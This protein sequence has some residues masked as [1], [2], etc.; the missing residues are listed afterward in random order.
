MI[1]RRLG[2]LV[3]SRAARTRRR[4]APRP[5][6]PDGRRGSAAI[7]RSG[8]SIRGSFRRR[9][10]RP[11]LGSVRCGAVGAADRR[12]PGCE[13]L[14]LAERDLAGLAQ[15]E[16][17][18][19]APR[20]ARRARAPRPR[21]RS[22][23]RAGARAARGSARGTARRAG[24]AAPCGR[25]RRSAAEPRAHEARRRAL[26]DPAARAGARLAAR[27]APARAGTSGPAPS[28]S[29][30]SEP[31]GCLLHPPVLGEPSRELLGGLLRLELAE[32]GGLVRE[33][34]ARLQL[35]QR[36]DEDEELAAGLE[37][38]LVTLGHALDEREDDRRDV[39]LARLELLLQEQREEEVEGAFEGVER[40]ARAP[41]RASAARAEASRAAGR[42]SCSDG[43]ASSSASSA[44][45]VA[46]EPR[47]RTSALSQTSTSSREA[48]AISGRRQAELV[49][50]H[51]DVRLAAQEVGRGRRPH[52][53]SL[54][55]AFPRS[56][57]FLRTNGSSTARRGRLRD[58]QPD[59]ARAP[60]RG[61]R[62]SRAR[63]DRRGRA[64]PRARAGR[65]TPHRR[66]PSSETRSP[67]V[68]SSSG[69]GRA[70][71]EAA[72]RRARS[73]RRRCP[74]SGGAPTAR[75]GWRGSR[76]AR[77]AATTASASTSRRA[78]R[79]ASLRAVEPREH[80]AARDRARRG[81][82]APARARPVRCSSS[83]TASTSARRRSRARAVR[84]LTVPRRTPST[85]AVS[86]LRELEEVAARE[87]V[88]VALV[89]AV[90]GGEQRLSAPRAR[91][92]PPPET[93]PRLPEASAA[94]ARTPRDSRAA[95][96]SGA[97]CAPRWRRCAGA[98]A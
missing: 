69:L 91:A 81:R 11:C 80:A 76:R 92:R 67:S 93:G 70:P 2:Q 25:A 94:A 77:R 28:A 83:F 24:S 73:A 27:A 50:Q 57:S 3:Q 74:G 79:C 18:E 97:G 96:P 16:E 53:R 47:T 32:L 52:R 54:D 72:R 40:R 71:R 22:R 23:R 13:G 33:Q 48:G 5:S 26:R 36:R 89:E 60:R 98:T 85:S 68:S 59:R 20:P 44:R 29:R 15:L 87:H 88:A 58:E 6:A 49:E 55:R 37:V 43:S 63:R 34:R 31:G 78:P 46:L 56:A 30:S 38:E 39:D 41:G 7:R 10:C 66:P 45:R 75:P 12:R 35:E 19:E 42:V 84:D 86:S 9:V 14:G 65:T 61:T 62:R 90:H 64:P 4:A 17:R 21:C 1:L 82:R 8:L 51:D 95:A